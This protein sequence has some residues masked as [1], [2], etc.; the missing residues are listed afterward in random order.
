MPPESPLPDRFHQ[1]EELYHAA[2]EQSTA[3]RVA[4][5]SGVDPDIRREVESL[6]VQRSGGEF[7]ERPAIENAGSVAGEATLTAETLDMTLGPYRLQSRLGAGGMG[8]VY[9][10]LDTRLGRAVAIKMTREQF[11]ERFEREARAISALNHP[12][13]CTLYDVGPNY[14]VMEL[15]D[16]ETI[17]SR[18]KRGPLPI[19][20]AVEY[21]LQIL[22]ALAQAHERGI[23]HRDLK[24]GNIML[25]KSG[26]KVLDFGLAK[27]AYDDS[28]TASHMVMGT[29]AYMP[30][31][32]REGKPADAR[33]DI[34]S[35]GCVLYE[36]LTA[37]RVGSQKRI[38]SRP[39]E[40]IV[41][42]CLEEKPEQRFQ[43]VGEI[44]KELARIV[45]TENHWK[46]I[47]GVISFLVVVCVAAYL[48]LHRNPA[49]KTA[50]ASKQIVLLADIVNHTGDPTFDE[51]LR[52]SL[53]MRLENSP[54]LALLPGAR[55][56]KT[57]GLMVR[58]A[59]TNLTPEVAAEVCERSVSAAVIE[60]T[61]T[62]LGAEYELN[63]RARNCRTGDVLAQE[64]ETASSKSDVFKTLAHMT[65][66]FVPRVV[67]SLPQAEKY[68][69]LAVDATTP[70]L[71]AWRSW[72]S[73]AKAFQSN[74]QTA[75][76]VPMLKRAVEID[77]KFAIAY[78]YLARTYAD[79]GETELAAQSVTKAYELRDH[80]SD[81]ENF[82]ITFVYHRQVTRN[83]EIARQTLESWAQ[84]YPA[85]LHPHSFLSGFTSPGTGH[86][87]RAIDEGLKALAI[88]PDFPIAYE[89]IAWAYLYLNRPSDAE[90]LLRK[91]ADR[92][93]EITQFSFIRYALA[94]LKGDFA[95]M[96]REA[97]ERQGKLT[98]QGGFEH[99][100]SLTLAYQGRLKEANRLSE[101]AGLLAREAGLVERTGLFQ[102]T[103]ALWNALFGVREQAQRNAMAALSAPHGRDSAYGPAFALALLQDSARVRKTIAELEKR[104][105]EDTSVQFSYLPALRGSEFLNHG[106]AAK[107]LEATE[108]AT[109][110]DF[111]VPGTAYFTG[112]LFGALYPI[113]V[114]GLAYA[115]LGRH[116]EAA[117]EFQKILDHPGLMLNDPVGPMARLQL[118]RSLAAS[119]DRSR[120][121][122]VY[123]DLLAIWKDADPDL[124]VVQQAKSESAKLQ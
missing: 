82:F 92:K 114:R 48:Y 95:A 65:K 33:S 106:D 108:A 46:S 19:D 67:E 90:A 77:P 23:I 17:S 24:P 75:D 55:I 102:G 109:P 110:Y 100:E 5:L 115:R 122:A 32:Q 26:V 78:A 20:E 81:Q 54:G 27:S 107:A 41:C 43:S 91:A 11:S 111:A 45:D 89:N 25:A 44:E 35:F 123:N 30:P 103:N 6:L 39:L 13:I 28:I 22:A 52:Q 73:A 116:T 31:E 79:I 1:I 119:G 7:L 98:A 85:E 112:P 96:Q 99:Q 76:V 61:I 113:Y 74:A 16:G 84:K 93:I 34:Y 66:E 36:M 50:T 60:G 118:A 15:V 4:L 97:T 69:A 51:S 9:R 58:P 8:S 72:N 37:S 121:A 57:L 40:K 87:Q 80:V 63:L 104:F 2:R 47:L 105:P 101:R 21:A 88:D 12:N 120:S 59:N 29:P 14:L 56:T 94:F 68:P 18:L 49:A 62:S 3:D 70:S 10:A 53:A 117:A 38:P 86:Y 124:P 64:Q 71:E 42:R 83:L